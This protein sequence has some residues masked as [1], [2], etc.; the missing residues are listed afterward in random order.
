M[1]LR[2]RAATRP[3]RPC[4]L[5]H[6]WAPR[7]RLRTRGPPPWAER[8]GR[9]G[10]WP[11]QALPQ[12]F[13]CPAPA[14]PRAM[15]LWPPPLLPRLRPRRAP[16]RSA[17]PSRG[18]AAYFAPARRRRDALPRGGPAT[19]QAG[20]RDSWA[21]RSSLQSGPAHSRGDPHPRPRSR[22]APCPRGRARPGAGR[23]GSPGRR[24]TRCGTCAPGAQTSRGWGGR[25]RRSRHATLRPPRRV[26]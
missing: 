5:H 24:G 16:P 4:C 6:P 10:A 19:P 12:A 13:A 17:S 11:C 23:G 18:A 7:R 8:G 20:A 1:G 22:G 21:R 26:G 14:L 3:R 15:E 25:T 2:C 9:D